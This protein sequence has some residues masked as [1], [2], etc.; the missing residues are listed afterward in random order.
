MKTPSHEDEKS[1]LGIS[2]WESRQ[3]C[4]MAESRKVKNPIWQHA[5]SGFAFAASHL[6]FLCVNERE[7]INQK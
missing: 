5:F 1:A 6:K 7:T 4:A 3:S 2:H